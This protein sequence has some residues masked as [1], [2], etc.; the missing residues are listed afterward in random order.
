MG[1]AANS[2][3]KLT[4]L[5]KDERDEYREKLNETFT[6]L[7]TTLTLLI[8]R[9]GDVMLQ[10]DDYEFRSELERLDNYDDWLRIERDVR[11]CRNLKITAREMETIRKRLVG[12]LAFHDWDDLVGYIR[13]ILLGEQEL[14]NFVSRSLFQLATMEAQSDQELTQA[15][16]AVKEFRTELRTQR[17]LLISFEN[18]LLEEVI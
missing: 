9:L 5:P 8:I 17:R 2:F 16:K 11:L 6:L 15:R 13:E 1:K 14:A 10:E 12:K 18:K 4:S 7:D 3:K